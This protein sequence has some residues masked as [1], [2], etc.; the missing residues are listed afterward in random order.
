MAHD[1]RIFGPS[2]T[3]MPMTDEQ[4]ARERRSGR[5]A[6][7]AAIVAGIVFPA[8]LF[9]SQIIVRDRPEDNSPAELRFFHHHAG[10]LL[11]SSIVR[12]A[13]LMLLIVV[14]L[15]L[16]RATK[17]RNPD[18]NPVVAVVGVVG[19]AALA[20]GGLAHDLY[21][22]VV[23]ADFAGREFQS[24]AAADDLSGGPVTVLTVGLSVAGTLAL[25]FWFVIGSLN[26]M[27]IGLLTRFMGVLGVIIGPAFVL[28]FAPLVLTFWLVA[29]GVL[30]LGRWPRGMPAAWVA[31]EA[32]SWP[33]RRPLPA[34]GDEPSGGSRNGEVEAVGPAGR[35]QEE[36]PVETT[37][38]V[39]TGQ[40]RKRKRKR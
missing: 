6:G 25:A 10:P 9:W 23:S 38:P 3:A 14:A 27:R 26:A 5:Q 32:V 4:I 13:A 18:L 19:P 36:E 8:G 2:A 20:I 16:Y 40:R 12:F 1:L 28:G 11:A 30:L 24:I 37:A 34:D 33:P 15:H 22:A 31:G 39:R 17:A 21:L 35:K 7:L 29:L